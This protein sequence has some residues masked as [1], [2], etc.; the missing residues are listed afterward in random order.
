M[1]L[2]TLEDFQDL[3]TSIPSNRVVYRCGCHSRYCQGWAQF[4]E[5]PRDYRKYA[6]PEV[7]G[8]LIN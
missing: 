5:E 1:Q 6:L 8:P 2:V 7:Q 4:L 3:A